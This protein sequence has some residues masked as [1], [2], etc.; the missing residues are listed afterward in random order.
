MRVIQAESSVGGSVAVPNPQGDTSFESTAENQNPTA[1][2]IT[3]NKREKY[4]K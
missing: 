3:D 1:K 2:M 4:G